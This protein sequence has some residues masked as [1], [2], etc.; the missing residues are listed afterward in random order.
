MTAGAGN[1][2]AAAAAGHGHLRASHAD[3][4]RVIAVLK[5]AFVQGRLAKDEFDVRLNQTFAA[6]TYADLARLTADLPA[7]L[8]DAHPPRQPAAAPDQ[9]VSKPLLWGACAFI[10]AGTG[11]MAAAFPVGNFLLLVAGVLA[12]LVAAPVAGTLML[13]SWREKRSGGSLPPRAAQRD[14]ALD[15]ERTGRSGDDLILC[16]AREGTSARPGPDHRVARRPWRAPAGVISGLG[17]GA[18]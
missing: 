1:E 2:M 14:R 16:Q 13:D 7:G 8:I 12:I 18:P 17:C 5:V 6:R 11:S 9:P 3:R 15:G 4:E 10:V